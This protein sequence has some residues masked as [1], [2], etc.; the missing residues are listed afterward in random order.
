[1]SIL[2]T[3]K[4]NRIDQIAL[5]RLWIKCS[6]LSTSSNEDLSQ[7][8]RIIIK[9]PEF[10]VLCNLP[11]Q[12]ILDAKEPL[13]VFFAACSNAHESTT[14]AT[15]RRKI[16]DHLQAAITGFEKWVPIS[17]TP[18]AIIKIHIVIGLI[19]F[20]CSPIVYVRV[21]TLPPFAISNPKL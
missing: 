12:E 6:T 16:A 11:E 8:T 5:V 18:P 13:S 1:M 20:H 17:E 9:L 10:R 2:S 21:S 14:D 3:D 4:L 7:L 15:V 19:I